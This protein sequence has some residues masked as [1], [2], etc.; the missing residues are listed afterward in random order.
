MGP[1]RYPRR[2]PELP[3]V[4]SYRRLAETAVDRSIASV[5]TPD[6]WYLKSGTTSPTLRRLLVGHRITA[7]RRRGKL[8]LLDTDGGPVVGIR[9]GMTGM[10]TV[11]GASSVG[12]LISVPRRD[13]P[14]WDRCTLHFDDG[15]AMAVRD[16]RR[17]GASW[18]PPS[19]GRPPRSR[20]DCST[21]PGWPA[22]GT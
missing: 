14:R 22:S 11:D 18:L 17:L 16:P 21:R 20:P 5:A 7:A 8:L 4:E 1:P 15:G 3:E 10:L 12:Q 9:F 2:V 6:A 19:E 13:N